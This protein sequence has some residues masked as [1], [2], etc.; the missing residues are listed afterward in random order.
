MDLQIAGPAILALTLV[1][2]GYLLGY[3]R[4]RLSEVYIDNQASDPHV[5]MVI[6]LQQEEINWLRQEFDLNCAMG[7][8]DMRRR[9]DVEKDAYVAMFEKQSVRNE[10]QEQSRSDQ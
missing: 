10:L 3:Y 5:R 6:E 1:F 2:F 9:L 8:L 7:R 4:G